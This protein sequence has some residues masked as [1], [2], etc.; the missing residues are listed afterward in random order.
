MWLKKST[1]ELLSK[2]KIKFVVYKYLAIFTFFFLIIF[3]SSK[4]NNGDRFE[5]AEHNPISWK[6]AINNIP[7]YILDSFFMTIVAYFA[8]N[9]IAKRKKNNNKPPG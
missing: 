6:E 7:E 8:L 4:I 5:L 3:F 2:S 9:S 1:E